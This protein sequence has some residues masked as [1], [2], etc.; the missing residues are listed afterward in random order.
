MKKRRVPDNIQE[1]RR[2]N[3]IIA[4]SARG[5]KRSLAAK[6]RM[7]SSD[8]SHLI[9]GRRVFTDLIAREIEKS[10]GLAHMALDARSPFASLAFG[11]QS[12]AAAVLQARTDVSRLMSTTLALTAVNHPGESLVQSES[13]HYGGLDHLGLPPLAEALIK[14]LIQKSQE[15]RLTDDLALDLLNKLMQI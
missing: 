5:A 3:L 14:I 8:I 9:N 6:L 11:S 7:Y 13:T 1:I 15:G 2:H 4:T 10:L 12:K